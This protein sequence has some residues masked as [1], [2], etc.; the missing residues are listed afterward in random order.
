M[1]KKIID[2]ITAHLALC[3]CE[4]QITFLLSSCL[5]SVMCHSHI[6]KQKSKNI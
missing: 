4:G 3:Y 5:G 1:V 2:S 6:K